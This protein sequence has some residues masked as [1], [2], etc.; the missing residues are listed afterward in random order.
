MAT[1][2][3]IDDS[4]VVREVLTDSLENEGYEV[5]SA[6]TGKE[7]FE[8]WKNHRRNIDLVLLDHFLPNRVLGS[9]VLKKIRAIDPEANVI[10]LTG[11]EIQRDEYPGITTYI[12][13]KDGNCS[14]SDSLHDIIDMIKRVL[15]I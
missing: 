15:P 12:K 10:V 2:L 1:I 9:E 8:C 5:L 13:K 4:R 7:G 14:D 11:G 6:D 3:I